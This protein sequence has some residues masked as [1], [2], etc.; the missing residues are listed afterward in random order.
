MNIFD[1][2]NN[3]KYSFLKERLTNEDLYCVKTEEI[4]YADEQDITGTTINYLMIPIYPIAMSKEEGTWITNIMIHIHNNSNNTD[5]WCYISVGGE[6]VNEYEEL[7]V[8]GR[9]MGISLPKDILKAIYSESI[10][11][12]EYNEALFN[13]KM[14]EYMLNYMGIKGELGNFDSAIKALKWFGYGDRISISKLLRTDNEFK[15]QYIL[16][17]FDISYDILESFKTFTATAFISLMI[18]INKETGYQYPFTFCDNTGAWDDLSLASIEDNMSNKS[19]FYGENRPKMISLLDQYQ[20]IKIGNHD[21]PIENDDEKYWYWKPYFDFSFN[22]LG[23]KLVC[24]SY[25]YKKY[26]LPIHLNIHH[27]SLGYRVFANNI[28]LTNTLHIIENQPSI[29]LNDKNEV[30]FRGDGIH[31]FTKQIHY[32]DEYFNEFELGTIN[33]SNDNREW[34]YLNDTCVNIPIEFISNKFNKGYF[35]CVLLLQKSSNNEVL[36]ESHF[37]FY[38]NE[39]KTYKNFIIYPKKLNIISTENNIETKYFEYWINNDFGIK[40]LVNNKWYEYDFKLKIHNP[41]IDFGTLKYRYYFNDH[42][43]LFSKIMDNNDSAIHNIIFCDANNIDNIDN[44]LIDENYST[45]FKQGF[46]YVTYIEN[47]PNGY[48]CYLLDNSYVEE[49]DNDNN[50]IKLSWI[51][52][53]DKEDNENICYIYESFEKYN[54]LDCNNATIHVG[55]ITSINIDEPA[56]LICPSSWG[57]P[58]FIK[59]DLKL[60]NNYIYDTFN[61]GYNDN[62]WIQSFNI[63]EAEYIYQFFKQNYNLLSPFK[64]IRYIDNEHNQIMFNSYMHNKQLVDMNEINFDVNL[65][66]I[67]KYHLEHNLLYIDGTLL[68]GDFYQYIIYT[69]VLGNNHEVYINNDLV[70]QD[71]IL[72]TSYIENNDK[73]LLCA[74]DGYTYVLAERTISEEENADYVILNADELTDELFRYENEEAFVE[75]DNLKEFEFETITENE[76]PVYVL[77]EQY[78]QKKISKQLKIRNNIYDDISNKTLFKTENTEHM[79]IYEYIE[80]KYDPVKNIYYIETE[81]E[82]NKHEYEIYDKLYSNTDKIY[83]RYSSLINLPNNLKYKNSIHLFGIYE[84]YIEET[85]VLI[86]HNNLDIY[87]DGLHF[88]HGVTRN[89]DNDEQLKIY[90]QGVLDSNIDTRFPDTYGLYWTHPL[91]D[92]HKPILPSQVIE[93]KDRLG[94]Y[95]QRD[96]QKYFEPRNNEQ[97]INLWDCPNLYKFDTKEFTYYIE[98]KEICIGSI[99]YKTLDKF[100][101]NE[102]LQQNLNEDFSDIDIYIKDIDNE[103][104]YCFDDKELLNINDLSKHYVNKLNYSIEFL[105]ENNDVIEDISLNMIDNVEYNKINVTFYYHQAH[106]VRNRFYTINDYLNY[107]KNNNIENNSTITV[108]DNINYLNIEIN[109]SLYIIELIDFNNKYIYR[110]EERNHLISNQNPSMYWYNLDNNSLQS[111]PSYLNEIER[112]VYNENDSFETIKENLDSYFDNFNGN[113]Y[114]EDEDIVRYRFKNYL[115]KDLTGYKGH[116]KIEFITNIDE[117]ANMHIEIIDKD[118]NII[119]YTESDDE[120]DLI[121]DELKVTVFIS[122]NSDIIQ[123]WQDRTDIYIIP[124]LIKV[125]TIEQRLEYDAE[126]SSS[127]KFNEN[128]VQV[129]NLINVKYL[130]KEFEYG[131]NNN[132]FIYNLYNDFF[133]LKFNVYDSY[134]DNKELKNILLHSIYEYD[135]SLKLDTYLNYDFY[136]MHDDKYWYGLYI[137]QETCDKIRSLDDLKIIN[138]NDK[139]KILNNKYILNYEKSSEEYLINRLEFNTSE[140]FNQF[141]NDDIVCCYIHNN[142]RLPFNANISTKWKI[143]PMSLGMSIGTE[144]TSNG[145]MTIL[146]LPTNNSK[147]ENG[148][149][150]VTVKYSLDRDIQHQFKNTNIIRIS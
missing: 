8:N 42:N 104:I 16:D 140:G 91:N 50:S 43:Y 20:K 145:E 148:Y 101:N 90:I 48:E 37:N 79:F 116:Y 112:Y 27:T 80:F 73:L 92:G 106:I 38:Q 119:N 133:K 53:W 131:D 32:I 103:H 33:I 59:N 75:Y 15:Q 147:Y 21:M 66:L 35:N 146:S 71:F 108:K 149:Y 7:V 97:Q 150:K 17:Y 28:K 136:L 58:L 49:T 70:G 93:I 13:I 19:F 64:Q 111:L 87:I 144:F 109:N 54:V 78:N 123:N 41:T 130:N 45:L 120:F 94:F 143:E 61:I 62:T 139:K 9:N 1:E 88:T 22:E 83:S 67:L 25:Y 44:Q 39:Q 124:K 114:A 126:Q 11:N 127:R 100:Y 142:D 2:D 14:K 56:L 115:V 26:F 69:D 125:N 98:D 10:Y 6:F 102:K 36:Y 29:I 23:I 99:L 113:R 110:D 30:K 51:L 89:V 60:I 55:Q 84:N 68:D 129:P 3:E 31:Y 47:L 4:K 63:N 96:A 46:L 134:F 77:N 121:G 24:L 118:K 107:L 81:D 141:N 74:Y 117:Y 5:E 85:N 65:Q 82:S 128:N 76:E 40:L 12:D 18:Y 122:I 132:E 95:V 52:N 72:D 57:R 105:N 137:S 86:F 138:S 34:Y 135:E